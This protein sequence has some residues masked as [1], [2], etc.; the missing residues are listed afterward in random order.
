MV[1]CSAYYS[2]IDD[3][4]RKGIEMKGHANWSGRVPRST[5]EAFGPGHQ[6]DAPVPNPD[7]GWHVVIAACLM[8][9]IGLAFG[10]NP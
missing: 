7:T 1:F 10:W 2:S 9:L 6:L 3:A 4:T 5:E 8:V